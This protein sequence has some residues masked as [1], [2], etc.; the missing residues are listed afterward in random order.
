MAKAIGQFVVTH[1]KETPN[2]KNIFGCVCMLQ[3][4]I[5]AQST[6]K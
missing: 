6:E 3:G 1:G 2:E 5:K 4:K